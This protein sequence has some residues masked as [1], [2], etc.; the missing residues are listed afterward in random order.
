MPVTIVYDDGILSALPNLSGYTF[1]NQFNTA[2]GALIESSSVTRL[3]FDILSGTGHVY[4]SI[5]GPVS[6][7]TAP[8]IARISVPVSSGWNIVTVG[9]YAGSGSFQ[10][11]VWYGAGNAVGLGSG[12]IAGQGHHGMA[13]ND[14]V[15]TDWQTLPGLNALLRAS[16]TL[17]PVELMD[18]TVSDE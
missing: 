16:T 18:F 4:V 15:G 12:T 1:G 8:L 11:G 9:P 17:I 2:S 5:F 6:G 13:I 10:A 7:T 3:S 14:I